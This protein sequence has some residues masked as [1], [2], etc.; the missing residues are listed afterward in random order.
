MGFVGGVGNI[1]IVTALPM[2]NFV[3][4]YVSIF[5]SLW[6]IYILFLCL[7]GTSVSGCGD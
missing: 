1:T 2:L 5:I 7:P 4:N 3:F 6:F